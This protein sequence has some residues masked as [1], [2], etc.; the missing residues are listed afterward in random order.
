MCQTTARATPRSYLPRDLP[1]ESR[2]SHSIPL[3]Y[4][5]KVRVRYN[6][7]AVR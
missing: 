7:N 3:L 1:P 6:E 5:E 2:A 4:R